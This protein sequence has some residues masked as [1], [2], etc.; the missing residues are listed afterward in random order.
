MCAL[1]AHGVTP[2]VMAVEVISDELVARGVDVA[3][4]VTADAAREVLG[5]AG[6][7]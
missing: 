7:A 4:Q 5:R 3:A 1:A 2:A 6:I